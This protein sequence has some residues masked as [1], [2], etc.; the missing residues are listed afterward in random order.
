MKKIITVLLFVIGLSGLSYGQSEEALNIFGYFQTEFKQTLPSTFTMQFGPQT[1]E[2]KTPGTNTFKNNQLNLFLQKD[3]KISNFNFTSFVNFEVT[4][5]FS[6]FRNW[7]TFSMEEAWVKANFSDA[8]NLKVGQLIPEFNALNTM[9]NR[10]PFLPYSER[11]VIYETNYRNEWMP[12]FLP[13]YAFIQIYGKIP[14]TEKVKFEY[15]VYGGNLSGPY[16]S[17]GASA[18]PE[19]KTDF[20]MVGGRVGI[21][22]DNIRAGI[23]ST[24]DR[25]VDT[26]FQFGNLN[27]KLPRIRLG[28]DIALHYFGFTL[29]AEYT[30]VNYSLSNAHTSWLKANGYPNY[31]YNTNVVPAQ[32]KVADIQ[33]AI[34]DETNQNV[35]NLLNA[36]LTTAQADLSTKMSNYST[37]SSN[38][39]GVSDLNKLYYY[40]TL[41][42]NIF[43]ELFV[44]GF[45]NVVYDNASSTYSKGIEAFAGGASYRPSDYLVLKAEYT[46]VQFKAYPD[47]PATKWYSVAV[48]VMF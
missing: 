8:L 6:S 22:Y 17:T 23:S 16:L 7:G 31:L 21:I 1:I 26:M 48:S 20:K 36:S 10:T 35:K 37:A 19:D 18:T 43:D 38:M 40:V 9:K 15:A 34:T 2:F 45:Y 14:F 41:G 39:S 46:A 4:G 30:A 3:F 33:K 25:E 29:E 44:Y 28:G 24:W 47:F 5:S 11:P 12:M 32:Q 27:N 13:E 42:Y